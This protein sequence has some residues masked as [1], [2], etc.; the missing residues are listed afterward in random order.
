[1]CTSPIQMT[2]VE[3]VQGGSGQAEQ[4]V[5]PEFSPLSEAQKDRYEEGGRSSTATVQITLSLSF[6]GTSVRRA[7]EGPALSRHVRP[8]GGTLGEA[9]GTDAALSPRPGAAAAGR[10]GQPARAPGSGSRSTYAH[11][12][13]RATWPKPK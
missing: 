7:E 13:A 1:M 4:V 12:R 9:G 5:G 8:C 6:G 2:E 11:L 3:R 10:S